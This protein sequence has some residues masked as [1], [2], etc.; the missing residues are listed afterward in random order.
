MRRAVFL[1]AGVLLV[2][3]GGV[4]TLQGLNLLGASG[5]MNGVRIWV[6]IGPLVAIGGVALIVAGVRSRPGTTTGPEA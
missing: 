1:I 4:W 3:T 2:L 5:G 6:V